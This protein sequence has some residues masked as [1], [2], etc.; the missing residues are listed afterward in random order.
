METKNI[1]SFDLLKFIMALVIVAHHSAIREVSSTVE[2]LF[3]PLNWVSVP[4][5]FILSSF[6]FLRKCR[7]NN[8]DW[9]LLISYTKRLSIL[10]LIWA[11]INT[12]FIF[13]KYY[14][15]IIDG[16]LLGG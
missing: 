1:Y 16:T 10:Y 12:P 4:V 13:P 11:F 3:N 9:I 14:S 15:S 2:M 5:F 6:F 7:E 8:F